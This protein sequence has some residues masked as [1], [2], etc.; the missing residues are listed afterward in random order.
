MLTQ[1]L[2]N[3]FSSEPPRK[4]FILWAHLKHLGTALLAPSR[5]TANR[6]TQSL[7]PDSPPRSSSNWNLCVLLREK[8]HASHIDGV[9]LGRCSQ[10]LLPSK[11]IPCSGRRSSHEA[12]CN[13][14]RCLNGARGAVLRAPHPARRRQVLPAIRRGAARLPPLL[15]LV[16]VATF[17]SRD[18]RFGS[19]ADITL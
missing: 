15:S 10:P 19:K 4:R 9:G 7:F 5:F 18:V 8:N 16:V 3:T 12:R 17:K 1:A 14:K 11:C 6:G 13:C 2:P